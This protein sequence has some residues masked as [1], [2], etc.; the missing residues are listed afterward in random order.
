MDSHGEGIA[1][2]ESS[3]SHSG[4]KKGRM[5][6]LLVGM[7]IIAVVVGQSA[8]LI[9]S[10]FYFEQGGHSLWLRSLLLRVGSPLLLLPPLLNPQRKSAMLAFVTTRYLLACGALGVIAG[11]NAL[12]YSFGIAYLPVST[13]SLLCATQLAFN[14]LFSFIVV[15]QRITPYILNSIVLLT[16]SAILLGA[17]S[18]SERPEGVNRTHFIL[19]FVYTILACAIYGLFLAL[20]Q[21]VFQHVAQNFTVVMISQ[22]LIYSVGAFICVLGL[23]ASG[24]FRDLGSESHEFRSGEMGYVMT[25]LWCAIAYQMYSL[26]TF[27]LI[28]LISSLFSNVIGALSLPVVPM[29]AVYFFHD[30]LDGI[31]VLAMLLG[32]WG[33][34][35]YV[36]GGYKDSK[37]AAHAGARTVAET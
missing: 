33:F 7:S 5:H 22:A 6:W 19:G 16:F 4:I 32:I 26:G 11:G 34:V 36:F 10:R 14:A 2:A 27:G 23:L 35:S 3:E 9:L 37:V 29:L 17:Q 25:L 13:Y 15:K 30:K 21:L 8:A 31:K 20:L 28:F 1:G 12:L 18:S 24:E